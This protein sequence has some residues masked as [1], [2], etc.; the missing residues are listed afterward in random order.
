MNKAEIPLAQR[1][2]L[3]LMLDG[4]CA[5]KKL[6]K[7]FGKTADPEIR[8]AIAHEACMTLTVL[9][10]IEEELFYPFLRAQNPAAFGRLLDKAVVEHGVARNLIAQIQGMT[11]DDPLFHARVSVLGEYIGHH[12]EEEEGELFPKL[13]VLNVDLR[14]IA[15]KLQQRKEEIAT[16]AHLA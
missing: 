2:A 10:Q 5:V 1:D 7:D 14:D 3:T 15:K 12:I 4:H 11:S 9:A 13:V 16:V 8:E 6:F